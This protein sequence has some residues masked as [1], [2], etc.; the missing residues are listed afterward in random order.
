MSH[1]SDLLQEAIH[2]IIEVKEESDIMS[3]FSRVK[4]L[5]FEIKYQGLMILS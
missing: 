2:S 5:H 1:Y 3:L 4:L